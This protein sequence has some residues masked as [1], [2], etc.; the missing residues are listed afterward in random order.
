MKIF[1]TWLVHL[2]TQLFAQRSNVFLPCC[3]TDDDMV[4]VVIPLVKIRGKIPLKHLANGLVK[5]DLLLMAP[6]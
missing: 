1:R 4:G 3:K 5:E 2:A 6:K